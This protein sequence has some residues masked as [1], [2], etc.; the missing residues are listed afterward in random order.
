MS[1]FVTDF[2]RIP[3]RKRNFVR[4]LFAD[5]QMRTLYQAWESVAHACVTQLRAEGA[6]CPGDARLAE[7]LGELSVL[8][9]QFRQWWGAARLTPVPVGTKALRHPLVGELTLTWDSFTC[10]TDP[11]QRPVI[12]TP[13]AGTPSQDGLRLLSSWIVSPSERLSDAA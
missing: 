7:L 12:W 13:E 11:E 2:P 9:R 4:L 1:A 3:S 5:P 6:K 10:T 8:E